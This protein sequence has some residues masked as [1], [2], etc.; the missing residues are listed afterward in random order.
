MCHEPDKNKDAMMVRHA[1]FA[2]PGMGFQETF[3]EWS[4]YN[5]E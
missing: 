3:D 1:S 4:Q 5:T 2:I